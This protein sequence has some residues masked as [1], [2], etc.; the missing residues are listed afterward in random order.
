M[1]KEKSEKAFVILSIMANSKFNGNVYLPSRLYGI[2][3]VVFICYGIFGNGHL[4]YSHKQ[5]HLWTQGYDK[6]KVKEYLQ[7]KELTDKNLSDALMLVLLLTIAEKLIID[8]DILT[9]IKETVNKHVKRLSEME[10]E[11]C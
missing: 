9:D 4:I 7:Q 10:M 2:W 6:M 5:V 3:F 11:E 1:Y 8:E